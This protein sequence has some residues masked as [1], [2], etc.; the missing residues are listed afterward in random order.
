MESPWEE[1]IL[2]SSFTKEFLVLTRFACASLR[3]SGFGYL[4]GDGTVNKKRPVELWIT[5]RMTHVFALASLC[6]IAGMSEFAEH[7]I[8]SLT[9]AFRDHENGGWFSAVEHGIDENGHGHY[10]GD[11]RKEAYAHAFVI[12]AASSALTAGI[13]GARQLLEDAL[14]DQDT[15]WWEPEHGRVCESWDKE[16]TQKEAYRGLNSNMHTVEAYLA[17]YHATGERL[18]LDRARAITRWAADLCAQWGAR[19]PEHFDS[20]WAVQTDFNKE[21]PHDPFRP[22]GVTPGHACEWARLMLHVRGALRENGD[23]IPDWTL[24]AP[25]ALFSRAAEEGWDSKHGGFVYTTDFDGQPVVTERMHWV[26]CEALSAAMVLGREL[27]VVGRTQ[28]AEE[29]SDFFASWLAWADQYLREDI[30][31]WVHEVNENGDVSTTT[32][33]GKPDVYHVAQMLL[34]PLLPPAASFA[35][36]ARR[37]RESHSFL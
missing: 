30:G 23:E 9:T 36:S 4:M 15:H 33:D 35:E 10:V 29:V 5:A 3:P 24:E 25:H 37:A 32:W 34:L 28:D 18:W 8:R 19:L 16:Y 22:Y 14:A 7:G 21:N 12:L 2:Q 20:K 6:G 1:P 11:G 26:L 27:H 31:R 17:A 13:E